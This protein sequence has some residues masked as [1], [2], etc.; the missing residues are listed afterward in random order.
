MM[1]VAGWGTTSE[2]GTLSDVP[3]RAAVPITND[4]V[5]RSSY[6]SNYD[7]DFMICAGFDEGGYDACQGDSG[8]PL[9]GADAAG[10]HVLVGVVSFG[11]GCA[12]PGFPGV[13]ARA[14]T[15]RNWICEQTRGPG[16]DF[17]LGACNANAIVDPTP[18]S[19][20]P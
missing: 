14:S 8:G 4:Q 3:L 18:P 6:G 11:Q 5:C 2:G 7:P 16:G 20:S 9:F 13:Y 10:S 17:S 12:R 19:T 1:I 15:Y